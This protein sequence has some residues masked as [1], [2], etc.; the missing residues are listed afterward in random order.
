MSLTI[1]THYHLLNL[2]SATSNFQATSC[3]NE[4]P[5][6]RN[7]TAKYVKVTPG[8]SFEKTIMGRSPQWYIP[9]FVEIDPPVPVKKI[10]EGFLPYM[11]TVVI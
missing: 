9:S 5:K 2:L 3:N 10:L 8:S 4:K 7:L 1:N 11:G 6:L